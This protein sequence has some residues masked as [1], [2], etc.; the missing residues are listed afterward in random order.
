MVLGTFGLQ[1]TV[2]ENILPP[3][4][5]LECPGGWE[6][7]VGSSS[8]QHLKEMYELLE[9]PEEDVWIFSGT[10]HSISFAYKRQVEHR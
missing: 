4:K 8:P 2:P 10:T 7:E 6:E 3:Q 9:L 5:G 1:C